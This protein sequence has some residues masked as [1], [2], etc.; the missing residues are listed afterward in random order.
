MLDVKQFREIVIRPALKLI[1]LW[2]PEAE[3]LLLG[4]ALQESRLQ[5]L[6]QLG[7]GPA[8]GVFQMEP[9]THDDIWKNYLKYKPDLAKS[10]A[11]LSH[12]VNAPSLATDLLYAAA[13]C[14]VHYLRVP[15]RLPAEGDIQGQARYWKDHYNTYLGAGSA[16]EYLEVWEA[17]SGEHIT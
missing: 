11:K 1:K 14:R 3:E 16:E 10:V 5:Y 17:Y 6:K 13:M 9:R 12:S 15:E 4:T 7:S 8:L 2:S